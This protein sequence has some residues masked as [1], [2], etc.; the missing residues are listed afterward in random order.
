MDFVASGVT[1]SATL[2]QTL[3]DGR[4]QMVDLMLPSDFVGRPARETTP[5][6]VFAN[7][8]LMMCCFRKKQFESMMK[9][10]PHIAHRLLI[11]VGAEA[12]PEPRT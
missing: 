11:E 4:S 8:D 9:R 5:Y 10:T 7:T 1:G 6:K 2:T 12:C 3:K